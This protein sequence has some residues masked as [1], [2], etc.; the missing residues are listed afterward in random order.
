VKK[1]WN[2]SPAMT[3][4]GLTIGL[5]VFLF[6]FVLLLGTRKEAEVV[7]SDG[8]IEIKGQYGTSYE[9]SEINEIRLVDSM[10]KIGMKVNGAGLGEIKKGNFKVD[11]LGKCKLYIQKVNQGPYIYIDAK[12]KQDAFLNFT[13]PTKTQAVY[14]QLVKAIQ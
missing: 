3:V 1:K 5:A 10:P 14:D 8:M 6:V 2:D 12:G 11:G 4:I 7:I 9:I 13:D